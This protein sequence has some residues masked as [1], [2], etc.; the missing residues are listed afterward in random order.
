MTCPACGLENPPSALYCDCGREFVSGSKP[1][2]PAPAQSKRAP[3]AGFGCLLL[4]AIIVGLG[5]F[6]KNSSDKAETVNTTSKTGTRSSSSNRRVI[7]FNGD[8]TTVTIAQ[9][10]DALQLAIDLLKSKSDIAR[11]RVSAAEVDGKLYKVPNGTR[12]EVLGDV[13]VPSVQDMTLMRVRILNGPRSGEEGFCF[14]S[15]TQ[16]DA[17]P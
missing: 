4:I 15:V 7:L 11:A 9:D 6:V 17:A 12:A 10:A 2:Q 13:V 8:A 14:S 5:L 3:L 1:K 16:P